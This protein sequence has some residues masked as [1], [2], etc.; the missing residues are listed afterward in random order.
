MRGLCTTAGRPQISQP[1]P[2]TGIPGEVSSFWRRC[3]C[4]TSVAV[5]IE[6]NGAGNAAQGK[7]ADRFGLPSAY[8]NFFKKNLSRQA[9]PL[10]RQSACAAVDVVVAGRPRRKLE[11]PQPKGLGGQQTQQILTR[12]RHGE[13]TI[14]RS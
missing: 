10:G 14:S 9:R 13:T 6:T 2:A 3:S 5:K 12:G 4:R 11:L 8:P 1:A 7:A